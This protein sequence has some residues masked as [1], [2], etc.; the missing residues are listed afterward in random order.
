MPLSE[1]RGPSRIEFTQ[2]QTDVCLKQAEPKFVLRQL[3]VKAQLESTHRCIHDEVNEG[4]IDIK[5]SGKYIM[6]DKA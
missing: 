6:T 2:S 4:V 5:N 1:Q 3:C